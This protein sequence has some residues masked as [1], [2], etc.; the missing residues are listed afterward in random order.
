[1]KTVAAPGACCMV[2]T[3]AQHE[4]HPKVASLPEAGA[5][6]CD[7]DMRSLALAKGCPTWHAPEQLSP[8]MTHIDRATGSAVRQRSPCSAQSA[9]SGRHLTKL[10]GSTASHCKPQSMIARHRCLGDI[11]K[12]RSR[13]ACYEARAV[14][15]Y[16]PGRLQRAGC[17]QDVPTHVGQVCNK[18]LCSVTPASVEP[19]C[20]GLPA[21]QCRSVL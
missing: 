4:L 21:L 5:C 14:N 2:R 3:A 13:A 11:L 6:D 1:M 9:L 8:Q 15:G 18:K 16:E 10:L 19:G 12:R 17:P 20:Q 7:C